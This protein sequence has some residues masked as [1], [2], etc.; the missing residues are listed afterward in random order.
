M[1][2]LVAKLYQRVS[3]FTIA[4]V[5]AVSS[6]TALVPFIL[7][8]N[9][10][11][12]GVIHFSDLSAWDLT[13]TRATGH[14]E[15]T[16]SGLRVWTEGATSTDKAA[17]YYN[18]PDLNLSDVDSTAINFDSYV[19]GRPSVQLVVDRDDNGTADGILVFEPWAYAPGNTYWTNG[20]GFGVPSG[21]GYASY[22]T[23]A[24]YQDA[25]PSAKILAI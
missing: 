13:Q 5:L 19:G 21:M 3:N 17:G 10:S 25:N 20:S 8:Q 23:L 9:A 22:G 4:A 14:N 18:T 11:A 1:R 24:Q 6:L 7:S 16:A 15:I 12:A 2:A